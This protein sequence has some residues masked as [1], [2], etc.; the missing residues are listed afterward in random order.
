MWE[1]DNSTFPYEILWRA[2]QTALNMAEIKDPHIRVDHLAIHSLL[3]GF[4]AF[5]GFINFVGEE[6]VPDVWAQERSFFSG[7]GFRGIVGKVEYLF[8]QFSGAVLKKGEEPYQTFDR[9]K[10]IRDNLAHNRVL[11]YQE[12]TE[13]EGPSLK[14][15]WED[16]DTPEKV[17]PALQQLKALAELIR[18]ESLKILKEEYQLSHLHFPAFEGPIAHSEGTNRG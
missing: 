15:Y 4:L 16:F 12:Q 1:R 9:V 3:S 17:R 10:R 18:I 2:A 8:S 13:S 7:G 11:R 6:V 14:T 5:E